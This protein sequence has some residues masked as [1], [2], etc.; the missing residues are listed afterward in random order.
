MPTMLLRYDISNNLC[1]VCKLKFLMFS[2]RSV[3]SK[4]LQHCDT[5]IDE[6]IDKL[7]PEI[8]TTHGVDERLKLFLYAHRN[9]ILNKQCLTYGIRR[10]ETMLN[11]GVNKI[12]PILRSIDKLCISTNVDINIGYYGLGCC[13]RKVV[14]AIKKGMKIYPEIFNNAKYK[15]FL[16]NN[17]KYREKYYRNN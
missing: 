13:D 12:V 9:E 10:Y 14:R 11:L 2:N 16:M 17:R 5:E 3:C 7:K 1:K 6:F 4:C 8:K 15:D